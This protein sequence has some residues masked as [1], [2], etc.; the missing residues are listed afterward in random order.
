MPGLEQESAYNATNFAQKDSSPINTTVCGQLVQTFLC[1]SDPQSGSQAFNDR[2]TVFGRTN[3]GSCDGDWYVFSFPARAELAGMP[4][5][6][7]F[8]V[9]RAAGSP[10]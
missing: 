6:T 1:P 2:G 5:R 3:Y 10:S 4:S 8:T 9:N 7:A